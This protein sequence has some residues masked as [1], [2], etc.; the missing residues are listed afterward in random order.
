MATWEKTWQMLN[1]QNDAGHAS[2]NETGQAIAWWLKQFLTGAFGFKDANGDAVASPVGAWHVDCSSDGV[3][4]GVLGDG[5]DRWVAH[6]NLLGAAAG[7]PH[8]WCLLKSINNF[9]GLG[10]PIYY[11]IDRRAASMALLYVILGKLTDGAN[12]TIQNAPAMATYGTSAYSNVGKSGL[13]AAQR[14]NGALAT[15]G[16]FCVFEG[17]VASSFANTVWMVTAIASAEVIAGDLYP[18]F[19]HVSN[20]ATTPGGA[21]TGSF[22]TWQGRAHDGNAVTTVGPQQ[23][24]IGGNDIFGG[25]GIATTGDAIS[26][27]GPVMAVHVATLSSG[28]TA[29]RGRCPDVRFAPENMVNKVEPISGR[30]NSVVVGQTLQPCYEQ[31]TF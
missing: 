15:D 2:V 18:F 17:A 5:V 10:Y 6:T 4:A 3:T 12:G 24:M 14:L 22:S 1:N 26:G 21:A 16:T 29:F 25:T 19:G 23:Q 8:A 20:Q 9:A 11:L 7:S 27:L 31:P 30:P 28:K 13:A